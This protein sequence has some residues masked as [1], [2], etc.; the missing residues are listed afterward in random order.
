LTLNSLVFAELANKIQSDENVSES[1]RRVC[2]NLLDSL[3]KFHSVPTFSSVE[4]G[5]GCFYWVDSRLCCDVDGDGIIY[6]EQLGDGVGEEL[7]CSVEE[8][9]A[10]LSRHLKLAE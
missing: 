7:E 9:Y 5:G 8:V 3:R 2:I 1:A 4:D 6:V 10:R